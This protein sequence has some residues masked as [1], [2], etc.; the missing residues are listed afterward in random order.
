MALVVE[1]ELGVEGSAR[2]YGEWRRRRF[3]EVA[4]V[5]L[6]TSAFCISVRSGRNHGEAVSGAREALA[7]EGFCIITEID[8]RQAMQEKLGEAFLPYTILGACN[9]HF[10]REA[11]AKRADAG[12]VVA[13]NVV[14]YE[15]EGD[16]VIA[17]V[18]PLRMLRLMGENP[19]LQ[20]VAAL[21]RGR[22][23]AALVSLGNSV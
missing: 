9:P 23:E 13:C 3:Q 21:V 12:L 15:H 5:I 2:S 16:S 4:E 1:C 10:A 17:A 7:R 11:L 19:D 14:V 8:V 18:D 20:N 22:L 6:E